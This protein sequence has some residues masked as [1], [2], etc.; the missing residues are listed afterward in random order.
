MKTKKGLTLTMIFEASSLNYGEGLGNVTMLKKVTKADGRTYT[1]VSRQALRYNIIEN[2]GVDTTPVTAES[3]VV[4]FDPTAQIDKYPEIDLFGYMKTQKESN[5]QKRSAV[6]RLSNAESLMPFGQDMDFLNNMGLANRCDAPN[7]LANSEIHNSMY[8]YTVVVDLDRV[9]I[10][11]EIEI[12]QEEKANRICELLD[13]IR[14][15]SRD[16]KGRTESL[17]PIFGIGG[18]YDIKN[19]FFMGNVKVKKGN[20]NCDLLREI[21]RSS[22]YT[23]DKTYIA[24]LADRFENAEEIND[25]SN[26]SM[27]ELFEELKKE[28]KAYYESC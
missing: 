13:C 18:I 1:Y 20:L 23:K 25:L 27:S 15:L 3:G 19:P 21:V 4:Q 14:Y 12:T 28:V 10:D 22:P 6:V 5:G 8:A 24:A 9:G 7:A 17:N 16:I 11:G 26:T 2:M